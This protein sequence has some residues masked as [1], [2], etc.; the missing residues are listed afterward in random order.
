ML[1]RWKPRSVANNHTL[2]MW[3]SVVS[4]SLAAPITNAPV[5]GLRQR[6]LATLRR[7]TARYSM[8]SSYPLPD[9]AGVRSHP[10]PRST[11]P[12][13]A[14]G[15]LLGWTSTPQRR[16][17]EQDTLADKG[18]YDTAGCIYKEDSKWKENLLKIYCMKMISPTARVLC[19]RIATTHVKPRSQAYRLF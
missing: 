5:Q 15:R 12:R 7:L 8:H 16:E 3:L 11:T 4:S 13:F 18:H 10:N 6:P 14:C 19:V 17:I 9:M 2:T 1:T